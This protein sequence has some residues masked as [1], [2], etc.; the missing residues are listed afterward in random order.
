VSLG[1]TLRG[2]IGDAMFCKSCIKRIIDEFG[3]IDILVNNAAEQ[4]VC[5]KLEDIS[6][7]Q[8]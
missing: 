6:Q 2:D 1:L 5:K 7:E 4:P 8:L 3:Q